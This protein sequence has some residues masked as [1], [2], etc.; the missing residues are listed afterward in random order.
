MMLSQYVYNENHT[1][2]I[3]IE[4]LKAITAHTVSATVS[5]TSTKPDM[6]LYGELL[7]RRVHLSGTDVRSGQGLSV[8]DFYLFEANNPYN[9]KNHTLISN[10]IRQ[11]DNK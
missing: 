8:G 1:L 10:M 5:D 2:M 4:C 7:V 6:K 9:V 11:K 3:G